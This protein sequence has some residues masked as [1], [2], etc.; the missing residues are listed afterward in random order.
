[1][2]F[3]GRANLGPGWKMAC[4]PE[5]SDLSRVLDLRF[6]HLLPA[7][8]TPLIDDAFA[9]VERTIRAE[10]AARPT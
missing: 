6:R 4:A 5:A 7:H 2:G 9:C 8:G 3:F 10:I 1:M